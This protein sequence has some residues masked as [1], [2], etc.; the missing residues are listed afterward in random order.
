MPDRQRTVDT[1]LPTTEA[2]VPFRP[3]RIKR[4]VH[5]LG[6]INRRD[7]TIFVGMFAAWMALQAIS[8]LAPGNAFVVSPVYSIAIEFNFNENIVG[9]TML[10]NSI[11]LAWCLADRPPRVKAWVALMSGVL[12]IFWALMM[13][14]SGF[15]VHFF[16]GAAVWTVVASFVLIHGASPFSTSAQTPEAPHVPL[17]MSPRPWDPCE[18]HG[19]LEQSI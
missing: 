1:C 14:F 18:D 7:P 5:A 19:D 12:W 8:L 11:V 4:L 9:C 13:L 2:N 17:P 16:S 6:A 15:R 3:H 10:G